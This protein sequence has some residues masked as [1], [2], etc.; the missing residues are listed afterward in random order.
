[1][2][3]SLAI[4]CDELH[5]THLDNIIHEIIGGL[6][7]KQWVNLPIKEFC[8]QK[9]KLGFEQRLRLTESMSEFVNDTP[10]KNLAG[11]CLP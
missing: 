6:S 5:I 2:N 4:V 1:M 10:S 8:T 3:K 7:V 11:G 9:E